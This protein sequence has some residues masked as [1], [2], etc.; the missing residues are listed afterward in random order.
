MLHASVWHLRSAVPEGKGASDSEIN[1][2]ATL[3]RFLNAWGK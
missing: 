2:G 3:V 1:D